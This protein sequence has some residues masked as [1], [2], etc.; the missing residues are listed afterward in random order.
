MGND[1]H[2]LSTDAHENMKK[3]DS[4]PEGY[5]PPDN[6]Y[7]CAY[8]Q[9]WVRIKMIWQLQLNPDEVDAIEKDIAAYNCDP[10]DFLYS[11]ADLQAQRQYMQDNSDMCGPH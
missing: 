6:A 1:F 4:G 9:H 11:V 3:S 7:K 2:L 10:N 8:L 5:L